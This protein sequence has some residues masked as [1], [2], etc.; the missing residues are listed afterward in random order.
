MTQERAVATGLITDPDPDA[1]CGRLYETIPRLQQ[2]G[3]FANFDSEAKR[4]IG[5]SVRSREPARSSGVRTRAGAT[6]GT[7]AKKLVRLYGRLPYSEFEGHGGNYGARVLFSNEG[8][9]MFIF[10]LND[11]GSPGRRV[12]ELYA[13]SGTSLNDVRGIVAC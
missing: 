5:I 6:V 12:S 7:T 4:L 8:A 1:D 13:T 11:E 2:H 10:Q 9:L 3:V